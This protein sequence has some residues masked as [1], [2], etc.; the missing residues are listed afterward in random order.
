M[1]AQILDFIGNARLSTFIIQTRVFAFGLAHFWC[2]IWLNAF[3]PQ[4]LIRP[5]NVYFHPLGNSHLHQNVFNF[6]YY[7]DKPRGDN[8][9]ARFEFLIIC[10]S[11]LSLLLRLNMKV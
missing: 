1:Q 9:V 10:Y 4:S 6:G 7:S 8:P 5:S 11:L 3:S 2:Q